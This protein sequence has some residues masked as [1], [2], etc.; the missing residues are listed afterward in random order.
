MLEQEQHGDDAIA[1]DAIS[2]FIH[3]FAQR[4][5]ATLLQIKTQFLYSMSTTNVEYDI[6]EKTK[7]L[8]GQV[9]IASLQQQQLKDDTVTGHKNIETFSTLLPLSI[10]A[11]VQ[12][13]KPTLTNIPQHKKNDTSAMIPQ[14]LFIE[15]TQ[16]IRTK[17]PMLMDMIEPSTDSITKTKPSPILIMITKC[18]H[19]ILQCMNKTILCDTAYRSTWSISLPM[20]SILL[21]NFHSI[22]P[23]EEISSIVESFIVLHNDSTTT[24]ANKKDT[25]NALST[26]LQ[27]VGIETFWSWITW[28]DTSSNDFSPSSKSRSNSNCNTI[29]AFDRAWV[30]SMM[31]SASSNRSGVPPR[32]EFF[33]RNV[34]EL[35]RQCDTL[36]KQSTS[37]TA[38]IRNASRT[39][40]VELWNLFPCFCSAIP[41][42]IVQVLPSLNV[43]LGRVLEDKRY[44]ELLVSAYQCQ[45]YRLVMS[46]PLSNQ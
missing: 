22:L 19:D 43:T 5:I 38:S 44:P 37:S 23:N 16:L 18:C 27:G 32:L 2:T 26:L 14:T 45:L 7:L 33:Q 39:R 46:S 40:V 3:Q 4:V 20:I 17:V 35:A 1:A 24:T 41:A 15:L 25:E 31:K 21:Q 9:M 8:Y 6:C 34:L 10:Q 28:N 13:C 42:D 29:I 30:L 36:S 11:I 12:L